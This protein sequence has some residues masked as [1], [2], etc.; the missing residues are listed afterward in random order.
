MEK[1]T[2]PAQ[3]LP[4][5]PK[6]TVCGGEVLIENHGGLMTYTREMIEVRGRSGYMRINGDELSL[7]AMTPT[8][9]AV[10]GL[11]VSIELC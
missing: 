7:S 3:L 9:I 11:I 5:E 6:L 1:M 8:D 2:L 4:N 10:R